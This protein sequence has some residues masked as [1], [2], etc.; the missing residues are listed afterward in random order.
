[1]LRSQAG[2][3][4][5]TA[6]SNLVPPGGVDAHTEQS[7][8]QLASDASRSTAALATKLVEEGI[9]SATRAVERGIDVAVPIVQSA[10]ELSAQYVVPLGDRIASSKSIATAIDAAATTIEK[11]FDR[12][13]GP[14]A[15]LESL[16]VHY[17]AAP[18][19]K[20]LGSF[21][22][23]ADKQTP[24]SLAAG[25]TGWARQTAATATSYVGDGSA[26]GSAAAADGGGGGG[27]G[28]LD[29]IFPPSPAFAG[30]S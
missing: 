13:Q 11:G 23:W 29:Q 9:E 22:A 4:V 19:D 14:V 7:T 30:L 3:A 21:S 27:G 15:R 6:A 18:I 17:V 5:A 25:V 20:R 2:V 24:A 28:L 12:V 26:G 8:A 1:M 16:V 10:E